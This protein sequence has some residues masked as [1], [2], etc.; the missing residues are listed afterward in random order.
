MSYFESICSAVKRSDFE[1][2]TRVMEGLIGLWYMCEERPDFTYM[3][4]RFLVPLW[5]EMGE[6]VDIDTIIK[7]FETDYDLEIIIDDTGKPC[8]LCDG[9]VFCYQDG[10]VVNF[11]ES[12]TDDND[13]DTVVLY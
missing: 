5:N 12:L 3:V 2:K 11:D 6:T 13:D 7:F 4:N 9:S 1:T 10:E 8:I